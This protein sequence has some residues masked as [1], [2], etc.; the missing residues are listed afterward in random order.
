M[1]LDASNPCRIFVTVG[2]QVAFDRLITAVDEFAQERDLD[3]VFAQIGPAASSPSRIDHAPFVSSDECRRLVDEADFVVAHAG[4]GSIISTL[5]AGKQIIVMPRKASLGEHRN[6]HQRDTVG[7]LA[8][9]PGVHVCHDEA[10]LKSKMAELLEASHEAIGVAG[11]AQPEL[12]DAL[13]SFVDAPADAGSVVGSS[14]GTTSKLVDRIVP[15]TLKPIRA[16]RKLV[17]RAPEKVSR[18]PAKVAAVT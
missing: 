12:L 16:A 5:Q 7:R 14:G 1:S 6:E 15:A 17:R 4:M 13:E 11:E 2:T 9:L 3:G 18:S 10:S 8:D